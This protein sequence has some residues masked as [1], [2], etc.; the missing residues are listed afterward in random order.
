MLENLEFSPCN[1]IVLAVTA[2]KGFAFV[3]WVCHLTGLG[4]L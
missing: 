1:Q 2:A 3:A 4:L